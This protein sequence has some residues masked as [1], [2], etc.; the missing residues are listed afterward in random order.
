V[1]ATVEETFHVRYLSALIADSLGCLRTARN[2]TSRKVNNALQQFFQTS[3]DLIKE[4]VFGSN[5]IL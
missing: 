4:Q 2:C 3:F 1:L 5:F